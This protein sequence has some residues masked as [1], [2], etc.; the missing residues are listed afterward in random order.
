MMGDRPVTA[1]RNG[2]SLPFVLSGFCV[3]IIVALL[4]VRLV[5]VYSPFIILALAFLPL[6]LY[7]FVS[8]CSYLVLGYLAFLPIIQH[9][10]VHGAMQGDLVITPHMVAQLFILIAAVNSFLYSYDDRRKSSHFNNLDKA[11]LLFVLLTFFSLIFAYSLPVN[12]VKRWLLFYTGIFENVTFYFVVVYVISRKEDLTDKILIALVLS[13]FSSALVAVQE[14]ND[15]G[16]GLANIFFSRM[17]IGFGYHNT[18][19]FGIHGA[20][21]FPI[22]FYTLISPRLRRFRVIAWFSFVLLTILSLLCFNRGTFIV[23]VIEIFL[24]YFIRENRKVLRWFLV[25]IIGIAAYFNRLL[26]FYLVRFVGGGG[27]TASSP[28][29]ASSFYRYEAWKVGLKLLYLYPFGV[30]AGG[31]QYAWQIY[32]PYPGLFLG[33]PHQLFLSIGVDYGVLPMTV[34]IVIL[35][36][37]FIYSERLSKA[38]VPNPHSQLF[39]YIKVS[40]VGFVIYGML[41]DGELSHLSGSTFPNNGYTLILFTLLAVISTHSSKYLR[42]PPTSL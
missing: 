16:F 24:L 29:D 8:D 11:L 19:L 30:G 37:A 13:S 6:L 3:Y 27:V 22:V 31:F 2:A 40:I 14:L 42:R 23:L 28:L 32:G 18:N 1:E 36:L 41:T 39:K 12:H 17:R 33:T 7:F 21:M 15:F 20:I 35:I 25:S 10:S 34:F 4:T 26:L 38:T 5:G 9:L